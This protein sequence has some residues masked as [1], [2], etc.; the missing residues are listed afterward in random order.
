MRSTHGLRYKTKHTMPSSQD[1]DAAMLAR[2]RASRTEP[3]RVVL[4]LVAGGRHVGD[5]VVDAIESLPW[6]STVQLRRWSDNWKAWLEWM[7]FE[8]MGWTMD[9][10]AAPHI[11]VFTPRGVT[12]LVGAVGQ[13]GIETPTAEAVAAG[14]DVGSVVFKGVRS[15]QP[16]DD[17]RML[18]YLITSKQ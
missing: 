10:D 17:S 11:A 14:A 12:Q 3:S 16:N 9:T 1:F 18:T 15:S 13:R 6:R 7:K 5:A 2:L 4:S 8:A